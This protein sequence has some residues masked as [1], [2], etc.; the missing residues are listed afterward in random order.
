MNGTQTLLADGLQQV[1]DLGVDVAGVGDGIRD[2]L[3]QRLAELPAQAMYSDLQCALG[4]SESRAHV[5]IRGSRAVTRQESLQG[6]EQRPFS[7]RD[8]VLA[9]LREHALEQDE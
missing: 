5:G 9:H 6:I 2:L 8:L 7:S 1:P 3:Y 4:H